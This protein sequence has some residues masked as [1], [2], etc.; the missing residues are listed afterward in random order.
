MRAGVATL[1][2]CVYFLS[3]F[4]LDVLVLSEIGKCKGSGSETDIDVQKKDFIQGMK[5]L[6]INKYFKSWGEG[7]TPI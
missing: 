1:Q 4:V 7:G 3:N 2:L 5:K 6:E